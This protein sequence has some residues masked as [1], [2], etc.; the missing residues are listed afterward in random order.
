MAISY[1]PREPREQYYETIRNWVNRYDDALVGIKETCLFA[2]DIGQEKAIDDKLKDIKQMIQ[3]LGITSLFSME[4]KMRQ[5]SKGFSAGNAKYFTT[6]TLTKSKKNALDKAGDLATI[7]GVDQPL[8][9]ISYSKHRPDLLSIISTKVTTYVYDENPDV[10]AT[11][12]GVLTYHG[13][14]C[15][16]EMRCSARSGSKMNRSREASKNKK[17]DQDDSYEEEKQSKRTNVKSA[18]RYGKGMAV[19]PQLSTLVSTSENSSSNWS[20]NKCS[21]S[22]KALTFV[23]GSCPTEVRGDKR[24]QMQVQMFCMCAPFA[25]LIHRSDTVVTYEV[26]ERAADCST[27]VKN[28]QKNFLK[29]NKSRQHNCN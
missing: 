23:N 8:K 29:T 4:E 7:S 20:K 13:V 28:M 6:D 2:I 14:Q 22:G 25:V 24:A 19:Q 18:D 5:R 27:H 11:P 21:F 17:I 15:P 3:D 9:G 26:I 1:Q 10:S 16:I 12:D